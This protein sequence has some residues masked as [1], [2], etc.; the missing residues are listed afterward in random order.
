MTELHREIGGL[1]AE[2][3]NVKD[4]LKDLEVKVDDIHTIVTKA[5]GGWLVLVLL[6]GLVMWLIQTIGPFLKMIVQ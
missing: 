1:Q 2:V 6:G 3:E 4:R 5:K